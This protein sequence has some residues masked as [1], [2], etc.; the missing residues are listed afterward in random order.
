MQ[1]GHT[2]EANRG[3]KSRFGPSHRRIGSAAVSRAA[4]VLGYELEAEAIQ[5]PAICH[6]DLRAL[7]NVLTECGVV[8]SHWGAHADLDRLS[9]FDDSATERIG[10]A[11]IGLCRCGPAGGE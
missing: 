4:V 7:R 10:L 6:G 3:V 5:L 2:G 9:R 1:P 8:S 11:C